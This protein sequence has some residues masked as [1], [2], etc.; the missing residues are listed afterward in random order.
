MPTNASEK[1]PMRMK[2]A[3]HNLNLTQV[4]LGDITGMNH[5]RICDYEIGRSEPSLNK[6]CKIAVALEVSIDWLLGT[7]EKSN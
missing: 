2:I 1:F 7:W 3:R 4:Q 5:R 6:L